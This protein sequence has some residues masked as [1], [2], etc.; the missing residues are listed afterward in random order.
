MATATTPRPALGDKELQE[1]LELIK[2]ADSVELK[3]TVPEQD[4]RSTDSGART[5]PA[6]GGDSPGVL[7]RHAGVGARPTAAWSYAPGG[8]RKRGTTR[9]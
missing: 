9:S 1:L 5:R 7:L 2:G 6:A 8:R 4:Q 3:L